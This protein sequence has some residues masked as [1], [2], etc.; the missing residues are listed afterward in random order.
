MRKPLALSARTMPLLANGFFRQA[1]HTSA[2]NDACR[3]CRMRRYTPAAT[4][5]VVFRKG[6]WCSG[7]TLHEIQNLAGQIQTYVEVAKE[8]RRDHAIDACG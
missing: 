7:R 4:S 2:S 3:N 1:H 6:D 5:V 8:G